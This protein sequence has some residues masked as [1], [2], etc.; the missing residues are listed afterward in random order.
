MKISNSTISNDMHE[1]DMLCETLKLLHQYEN[2]IK[3]G[4][5]KLRN[6]ERHSANDF[7][8]LLE[9][10]NLKTQFLLD[11]YRSTENNTY[12]EILIFNEPLTEKEIKKNYPD[13]CEDYLWYA[14]GEEWEV[15]KSYECWFDINDWKNFL[16]SRQHSYESDIQVISWKGIQID[17]SGFDREADEIAKDLANRG[18]ATRVKI[19]KQYTPKKK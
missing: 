3:E 9:K 1:N 19:T 6:G 11:F 5:Y 12:T 7:I 18:Y 16:D 2:K 10:I 8:S 15:H 14:N 13:I 17:R 4:G